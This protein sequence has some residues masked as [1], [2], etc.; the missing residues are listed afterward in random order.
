MAAH[1]IPANA[2]PTVG[3]AEGFALFWRSGRLAQH[4]TSDLQR[5]WWF[6][7][8]RVYGQGV[9]E[10]VARDADPHPG[11]DTEPVNPYTQFSPAWE[12]WAD[13]YEEA[14]GL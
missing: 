4:L 2:L 13:G 6:A 8:R 5:G 7:H 9:A 12:A 3:E 14:E 10:W 1:H 11:K